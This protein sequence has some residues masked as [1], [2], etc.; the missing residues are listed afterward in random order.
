MITNIEQLNQTIQDA[1]LNKDTYRE[2]I[3]NAIVF[4]VKEYNG[5]LTFN[6]SYLKDILLTTGN[7]ARDLYSWLKKY[8]NLTKIK[9]DLTHFE[10]EDCNEITNAKG[11]RIAVY[12]LKF[13]DNFNNQKWWET[14]K[15]QRIEKILDEESLEKLLVSVYN[16]AK[17]TGTETYTDKQNAILNLIKD[18]YRDKVKD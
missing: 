14:E 4:F 16:K 5:K 3:Q 10:T 18:A 8:T 6:S 1:K 15:K 13:R 11:E 17:K 2:L 7:D 12:T 9:S